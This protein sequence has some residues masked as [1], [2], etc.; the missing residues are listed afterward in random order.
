MSRSGSRRGR[1]GTFGGVFTPSVLTIL[2]LVLFLRLGFV[3]GRGGLIETLSILALATSISVTT[4]LSLAAIATNRK[5]RAGGDYYLISRS[6]GIAA[7]GA[8][9]LLLFAAQAFSAAFYCIGFG[10]GVATM[11]GSSSTG[12]VTLA[13]ASA[14]VVLLTLAFAGADLATRFQFVIML[15]LASA[16]V[17]FFFGGVGH[18]D[19]DV[20]RRNWRTPADGLGFWPLFAIF[21]P[22]V[23]GFTQGVSMSGELRDPGRSLPLGTF[24]A[25]GLST[26]VYLAVIVV[27]GGALPAEAL[28]TDTG[29]MRSLASHSW[30]VDAGVLSATLSSALASLLGAP[31][32]LQALARDGVFSSLSLFA[33]GSGASQNPRRAVLLTG[34]IALVDDRRRE[35]ELDR[36][37]G[38]DVLPDLLRASQLLDVRRGPRGEPELPPAVPLLSRAREPSRLGALRRRDARDRSDRG[39]DRGLDPRRRLPIRSEHRRSRALAGQPTGVQIPPRSRRPSRAGV[40][41]GATRGLAAADHRLHRQRGAPLRRCCGSRRGSPAARGS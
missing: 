35:P 8:L 27:L 36:S 26:A 29:A 9:G 34:T 3:I 11:L 16:L 38:V 18:F 6:L 24:L 25:V 30:L 40:S 31:R 2:G 17:S 37:A 39:R 28:G 14:G 5:V 7:G 13:A 12:V 21:F 10:E 4:S 22:A 1:L 32:I 20:L 33:K 15:I 19:A 23:T 41:R